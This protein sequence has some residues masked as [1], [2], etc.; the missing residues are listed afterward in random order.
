M[1]RAQRGD[2]RPERQGM[3]ASSGALLRRARQG[4]RSAAG[5]LFERHLPSLHRWARGRL[6]RWARQLG[7]TADIVQESLLSVFGQIETFEPRREGAFRAYLRQAVLNRIRDQYRQGVR[8]P[9]QVNLDSAHPAA[10][11]SPL[12]AAIG[13]EATAKYT[14]ALAALTPDEREAVVARIELGYS[15][16]QIA[17]L[18]RRRTPDAARM[19]VSRALAKLA[20]EMAHAPERR[21]S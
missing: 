12:E 14:A 7:D 10:G 1:A 5:V 20:R 3:L 18:V 2:P 9:M 21:D 19:M 8:R 15:Y 17:T 11:P 16:E 6:P 13:E 4:D